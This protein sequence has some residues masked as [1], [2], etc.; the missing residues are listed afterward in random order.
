MKVRGSIDPRV[1]KKVS[2]TTRVARA[3]LEPFLTDE[4][5][6]ASRAFFST[7]YS[8]LVFTVLTVGVESTIHSG[9]RMGTTVSLNAIVWVPTIVGHYSSPILPTSNRLTSW[10]MAPPPAC[11]SFPKNKPPRSPPYISPKRCIQD[12]RGGR[13]RGKQSTIKLQ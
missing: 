12:G 13:E 4:L 1:K 5:R 2:G 11:R 9:Y 7:R 8:Q 10:T 3:N 6:V